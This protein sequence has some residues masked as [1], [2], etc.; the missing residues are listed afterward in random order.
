[1]T[2]N[3]KKRKARVI[4][5]GGGT[6]GHIYPAIAIADGLKEAAGAEILYLGG[7]NSLEERLAAQAGLKFASFEARGL[8][9]RSLKAAAD[10]A[11]NLRGLRQAKTL[12]KEWRPDVVVGT[13]GFVSAPA[14]YAAV[15]AK[16]PVVLHEQN[17]F[18]GLANRFLSRYAAAVCLNFAEAGRHF[19]RKER[20]FITGLPVRKEILT[21]NREEAYV[22]FGIDE[23]KE[24][25]KPLLLITG[26]SQGAKSI[27][28]AAAAVYD[29]L[30]NA[31]ARI[32]HITGPKG[33]E[34]G[35]A[36]VE[37]KGL[38]Q[39][40]D[41]LL[42]PYLDR[43]DLAL[44]AADLVLSRAGASFLA[45]L[46]CRGT[47]ALL[48]PYPHAAANHQMSNAVALEKNGAALVLEDDRLERDLAG[49]LLP[50]LRDEERRCRL[51]A[52]ACGMGNPR[53]LDA[54]VGIVLSKAGF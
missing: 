4:V 50:L 21:A 10:L 47:P 3:S 28:K 52:A 11:V 25:K 5:S 9:R 48:S 53:A 31:P 30:L 42:F 7:K 32:I 22:Y 2:D 24:G 26:G 45:E 17:A 14:A 36:A 8:T 51:S 27:N 37:E 39:N 35:K 16:V 1:M 23:K 13:G 46:L 40:R 20:L 54:I 41:I 38:A 49:M 34:E 33:Y 6:G 18:P 29:T 12:I 44:A 43:M 19:A 15:L